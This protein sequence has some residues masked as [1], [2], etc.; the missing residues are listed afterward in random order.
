MGG[1]I[2]NEGRVEICINNVWGTVCDDSWGITDAT[3]VCQQLDFSVEGHYRL[4]SCTCLKVT[5]VLFLSTGAVPFVNAHFGAGVDPIH[6][7]NVGCTGT[8]G[9]LIECP[10]NSF[11][12]CYSG[13]REDAG[14]RCQGKSTLV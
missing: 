11:V 3:V 14:V 6:L 13:H 5:T 10:H 1:N 9:S 7:D 8:E 4:V 2:A 12:T